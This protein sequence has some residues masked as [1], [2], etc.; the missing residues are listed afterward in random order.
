MPPHDDLH[1]AVKPTASRVPRAGFVAHWSL[2]PAPVSAYAV[3]DP[4]LNVLLHVAECAPREAALT[5][6]ESA[7]RRG[8]ISMD[9][10]RRVHWAS[11]QAR[12]V[13]DACSVL[14]DSGIETIFRV[15]LEPFGLPIR[16]Q[17]WI[18]DHPVDFLIGD[19]LVAQIDG[20]EHHSSARDRRR[21]IS[22]DAGLALRGYTVLRFDYQQVMFDWPMVERTVLTAVAQDLHRAAASRA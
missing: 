18:D 14:S 10:L 19:L 12:A 5:V 9:V 15:R 20:F 6:W 7:L 21:D 4:L 13:A 17:V 16:Q 8:A 11:S 1:I 2:G 22:A 3:I